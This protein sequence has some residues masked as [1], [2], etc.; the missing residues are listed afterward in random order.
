MIPIGILEALDVLDHRIVELLIKL[1]LG[2]PLYLDDALGY[3]ALYLIQNIF[4]LSPRQRSVPKSAS[5][6]NPA[7]QLPDSQVVS[8]RAKPPFYGTHEVKDRSRWTLGRKA[9]SRFFNILP[10]RREGIMNALSK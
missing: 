10:G 4:P 8:E 1:F 5:F 7:A 3:A 9:I 2:A 6:L